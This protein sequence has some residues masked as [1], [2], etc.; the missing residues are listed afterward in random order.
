ME[1][2]EPKSTINSSINYLQNVLT[3]LKNSNRLQN[4]QIREFQN[5]IEDLDK[6]CESLEFYD[7]HPLYMLL[8]RELHS[9]MKGDVPIY[10]FEIR[11]NLRPGNHAPARL[12]FDLF[13]SE[14][15]GHP[16]NNFG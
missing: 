8:H 1:A 3:F 12:S 13:P 4:Y 10:A 11:V 9:L 14:P 2:L 5:V 7:N 6:V 15:I 16:P